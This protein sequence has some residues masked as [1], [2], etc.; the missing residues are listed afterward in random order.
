MKTVI[1][2]GGGAAGMMAAYASSLQGNKVILLEKNEKLGKKLF[3]TGKG[4]CNVTNACD[5]NEFFAS[6]ISN[7]K[8]LYS[9]IY[10]FDAFRVMDLLET[11]GCPLK[12]ERGERVF[13]VSD[14]S[15]D[16]I[17]TMEGIL[18]NNNVWIRK[19]VYCKDLILFDNLVQGVVIETEKGNIE[20]LCADAVILA[21]GGKS[22]ESTGSDGY[23]WKIAQK[24]GHSIIKPLPGLIPLTVKEDAC[25][26]L[27]GLSLKNVSVKLYDE[28]LLFYEGFGEMLFTHFGVSGP[29]ILSASS[30]L[31][32]HLR[33]KKQDCQ[34]YDK[35]KLVI[36][37][38]P[39]LSVEKLDKRI[40]R[41]FDENRKKK[42]KNILPELL[43]S[44]MIPIL[45]ML[46]SV[47][48]EKPICEV[49]KEEREELVSLMKKL[50]FTVTGTRNLNEAIITMGGVNVKE[51]N[52]STMESKIVKNLYFA[53]E[54]IDVDALT[55]GYNLQIAWSTG[56]LAG[57]NA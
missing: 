24:A 26:A 57:M 30:Y 40:L 46:L 36:D 5:T 19:N 44:K 49:T 28:T 15:S 3:L 18:R 8:F 16:V 34:N 52:P 7:P 39:A 21:L 25:V 31:G 43:P 22:Y 51:I 9:S 42:L 54:M 41:D 20:K 38:K 17:R 56:Y 29:L 33:K 35:I 23:G 55:G 6:V 12:I 11:N 32:K 2:A 50:T 13:P 53:G 48:L 47:D 1:V 10:G 37:L 14:H 45:P 4:R 27:Q